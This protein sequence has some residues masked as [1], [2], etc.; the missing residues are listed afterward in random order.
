M[1]NKENGNRVFEE[2]MRRIQEVTGKKTQ[3]A[4]ADF[5]GIRQ[6][7]VAAAKR[8]GKIP[9]DWLVT[10]IRAKDVPPEWILTGLGPRYIRT[11]T[12]GT[13]ETGDVAQERWNEEKALH[14]LSSKALADELIRRI[15]LAQADNFT[16]N[17]LGVP[18]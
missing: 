2:Q 1:D 14:G 4:L 8:R 15:A 10:I 16:R 18:Y 11:P 17:E 12:P 13:Y 7:S 5:L 3:E 6:S 9:A